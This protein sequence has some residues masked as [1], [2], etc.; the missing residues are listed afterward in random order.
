VTQIEGVDILKTFAT[1]LVGLGFV[2]GQES[3]PSFDLLKLLGAPVFGLKLLHV[4]IFFLAQCGTAD[5]AEPI[6]EV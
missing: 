3:E 6:H 1:F 5:S 2:V 4:S